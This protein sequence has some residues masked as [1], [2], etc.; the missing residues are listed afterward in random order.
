MTPSSP[1]GP[2]EV[3]DAAPMAIYAKD[4]AG[5]YTVMNDWAAA[6][7]GGSVGQT[8]HDFFP[9]EAADRIVETDRR[10]RESGEVI[11]GHEVPVGADGIPFDVISMKFPTPDGGVGGVTIP[12]DGDV[13][14]ITKLIAAATDGD[15][16]QA[17]L[18]RLPV[19]LIT[20]GRDGR[21]QAMNQPA[22]D[23]GNEIGEPP[24]AARDDRESLAV[25]LVAN[26]LREAKPTFMR[27]RLADGSTSVTI[28]FP[29]DPDT[30][31]FLGFTD[32]DE[33]GRQLDLVREDEVNRLRELVRELGGDPDA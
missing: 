11:V 8:D 18:A 1:S 20:L 24:P 7:A 10:V 15:P 9:P 5:V 19:G 17:V 3:I 29:V 26:I 6:R 33:L 23:L 31:A 13:R 27:N 14:G 12:I 30:V 16:L 4:A 28:A 2:N 25:E 22:R 32:Q 21:V